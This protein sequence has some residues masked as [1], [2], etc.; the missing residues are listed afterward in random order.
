MKYAHVG[1]F[2]PQMNDDGVFMNSKNLFQKSQEL[3]HMVAV[4]MIDSR[5]QLEMTP[6]NF[7]Q[8]TTVSLILVGF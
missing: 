8:I 4:H 5:N 2:I 3:Y 7:E 1:K 6:L